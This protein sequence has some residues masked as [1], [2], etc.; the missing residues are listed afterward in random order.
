REE[1]WVP[2]LGALNGT[3]IVLSLILYVVVM[4]RIG[5]ALS[6]FLF[7]LFLLLRLKVP[8][9]K[10]ATVAVITVGFILVVFGRIF[11]IQLPAGELG[12]PW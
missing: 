2:G 9:F 6:T 7:S 5:Y 4:D 10:A 11:L 3:I 12:L 8:F 1:R